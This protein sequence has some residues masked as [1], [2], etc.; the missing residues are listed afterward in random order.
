MIMAWRAGLRAVLVFL[1][2]AA[3]PASGTWAQAPSV[4]APRTQVVAFGLSD[5]LKVFHTEATNAAAIL[6]RSYGSAGKP[7]VYSN[8]PRASRATVANLRAALAQ[9]ASRMDRDNDVL[10]LFLTSHG[11]PRGIAISAGKSQT[12]LTPTELGWLLRDAGVRHKVLIVSA[13]FSGIFIPLADP[14]TLVMTAADATHPSFGCE[15]AASWTFFGRA[16]FTQ[17]I[18][19]TDTLSEAFAVARTAVLKRETREGYQP[20]NP[21]IAGGQNFAAQLHAA[22]RAQ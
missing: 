22:P 8:R 20:S 17:G 18:P 10:F 6:T 7:L 9:A 2:L 3:V 11:S 14:N 15:K 1:V 5:E 13:C 21:Q 16:L 4:P 19:K 12:L